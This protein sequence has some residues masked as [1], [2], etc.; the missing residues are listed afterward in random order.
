MKTLV[1]LLSSLTI[2]LHGEFVVF[3]DRRAPHPLD[4]VEAWLRDTDNIWRALSLTIIS[5]A[6]ERMKAR[7]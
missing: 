2:L 7:K 5:D 3:N 4:S 1:V 6:H